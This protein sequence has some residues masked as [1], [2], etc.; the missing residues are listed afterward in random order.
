IALRDALPGNLSDYDL[1]SR[2]AATPAP[3]TRQRGKLRTL[4]P[5]LGALVETSVSPPARTSEPARPELS[6]VAAKAPDGPICNTLLP[7]EIGADQADQEP[8][9]D[10]V[11]PTAALLSTSRKNE[12]D[13]AWQPLPP[14]KRRQRLLGVG[15][16]VL[17]GLL[18]AGG[19][20][21]G[22]WFL[23]GFGI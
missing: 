21:T 11:A 6:P 17:L 10:R 20:V 1:P 9:V 15:T 5:S 3:P 13:R 16:V 12:A 22:L 7:S 19:L 23:H 14:S 8:S 4:G 2:F 18:L